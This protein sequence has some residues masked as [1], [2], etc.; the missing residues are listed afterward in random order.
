MFFAAK[1]AYIKKGY[2]D[3]EDEEE[4]ASPKFGGRLERK[5]SFECFSVSSLNASMDEEDEDEV[6]N[7]DAIEGEDDIR[8]LSHAHIDYSPCS[9]DS[10]AA[11]V[12]DFS[13]MIPRQLSMPVV[14]Q[15]ANF[16]SSVHRRRS[17]SPPAKPM[18]MERLSSGEEVKAP[19]ALI[20]RA[21]QAKRAIRDP[22]REMFKQKVDSNV[23]AI[24]MSCLQEAGQVATG[25]AVF[26]K[27]CQGALNIFSKLEQ[28]DAGSQKWKCE[29]CE[30]ENEV[31][32]EPEEFPKNS[33]V[34]YLLM[35]ADVAAEE[36]LG[37]AELDSDISVIF[38][39]DISGSM[40]VTQ[41]VKGDIKLK[42][43]QQPKFE[44]FE[45]FDMME[46]YLP[47]DRGVTYISRMQCVQAS[48]ESQLEEMARAYPERKVGII[49]F[50]SD[51]TI[52]GDGTTDPYTLAGDKL[53][54]FQ[55]CY[56]AG[57]NLQSKLTQKI[58]DCKETLLDKLLRLEETGPTALG[59]A[60]LASVGL[61][62]KGRRGSKVIICTDGLANVGL[63][64]LSEIRN[65]EDEVSANAFY[66]KVGEIAREK[67]IEVSVISIKGEACKLS[68]LSKVSQLTNGEVNQVEPT[69]LA[70]DFANI[71]STPLIATRVTA[72]V[73]INRGLTFRNAEEDVVDETTLKQELGNVTADT[74]FTFEYY[75]RPKRELD[76]LGIDLDRVDKLTF[77]TQ[78][79]YTTMDGNMYMRVVSATQETTDDKN[80]AEKDV[81]IEVIGVN[82]AQAA[83]KAVQQGK[84]K[85]AQ[86]AMRGWRNM[87]KRNVK[88][89]EDL[90]SY[91]AYVS[92]LNV[93]QHEI[94]DH[95]EVKS[96]ANIESDSLHNA[97]Y[98]AGK[99]NKKKEC[100]VW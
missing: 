57:V 83:S 32:V 42:V 18:S 11:E 63:G 46:Q 56:E 4:E 43:R 22:N 24:R 6:Q 1:K 76:A 88:D 64:N 3:I 35:S 91:N 61:A 80:D 65:S 85:E 12:D 14:A 20:S 33:T 90:T 81:D 60:L 71:L 98:R 39:I 78:I 93:F 67:A 100:V 55:A 58:A 51:V 26:C 66:T 92:N 86:G 72:I 34:D 69:N 97:A 7:I 96:S 41:P 62:S 13:D 17:I 15:A 89:D 5:K 68:Y 84:Y 50:S 87:I 77:Q 40:C 54:S 74:E 2:N 28:T 44:G 38:C 25:D 37:G 30:L 75:V 47:G 16:S 19:Q 70:K 73:K 95:A 99:A 45:D 9:L 21:K 79:H 52:I 29:F 36:H 59:P 31:W 10:G 53:N 23:V 8:F 27:Q 82:A 94:R 48:I 49:T